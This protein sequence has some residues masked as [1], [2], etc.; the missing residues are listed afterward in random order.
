MMSISNTLLKLQLGKHA[1]VNLVILESF[2]LTLYSNRIFR[3]LFYISA[4]I[5]F[6]SKSCKQI[7]P[8]FSFAQVLLSYSVKLALTPKGTVRHLF[9]ITSQ[10][11]LYCVT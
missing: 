7:R 2:N 5:E 8:S 1:G 11:V 3:R 9:K 10:D 4:E 6:E